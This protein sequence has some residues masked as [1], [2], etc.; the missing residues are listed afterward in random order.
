MATQPPIKSAIRR[1]RIPQF[2]ILHF[3]FLILKPPIRLRRI[4]QFCLF[5][6]DFLTF[7]P[8][9]GRFEQRVNQN[10]LIMQNKPN[11]PA[12]RM[13]VS[14]VSTKCY[15]NT[16]LSCRPQNKPD[17][18]PIQSQP[19]PNHIGRL[20]V[21]VEGHPVSNLVCDMQPD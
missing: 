14:D 7:K 1:R 3:D 19:N 12:E 10:N 20:R 9:A 4:P 6:F 17:T 2:C 18:N 21:L 15:K 16:P 11:F 5:N 13:N 8:A